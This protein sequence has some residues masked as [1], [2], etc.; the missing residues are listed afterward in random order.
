MTALWLLVALAQAPSMG[1]DGD[2]VYL[3]QDGDRWHV[4]RR[5]ADGGLTR[6]PAAAPVL[7]APG[8]IAA[9][10]GDLFL[11]YVA[12]PIGSWPEAVAIGD[13][14]SDGRGD[15][16]VATSSYFDPDNDNR[17]HVFLQDSGGALG[18]ASKYLVGGNPQTIA[19]GDVNGDGRD[20]VV[21]GNNSAIGLFLQNEAGTLDPMMS[22]PTDRSFKVA[23]G[24]LDGDWRADVVGIDWGTHGHDVDVFLQ[25]GS[26]GLAAP[27]TYTVAH[28]G[29]DDLTVG[30]VDGDG[31]KDVTVMS[32]Q[33][34]AY[35]NLGI[36][37]QDPGGGMNGP[38]YYD[39]GG[40]QLTGGVGVGDV[41]GD[42]LNDVVVSYGG[43]RPSSFIAV[44]PQTVGGTLGAPM[45]LP[46]YDIPEPVEVSDVDGDGRHDV[47]V[48]HGG[49]LRLGVYLQQADGTLNPTE[50]LYP[51]PYASHYNPHGLAVGDLNG[52]GAVDVAIADYNQGLIVLYGTAIIEGADFHTL[53]PCRVIDTRDAIAPLGGPA[54]TTGSD[55]VFR[56][57]GTCEIPL[58]AK[59]VSVNMTVT[60]SSAPGHLRL[61]PGE[62]SVPP[63]SSIN[64]SEGQTRA[65]NA[66]VRLNEMGELA[67]FVGG[68]PGT[69]HFILDVG[70]Y[71]E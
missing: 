67:A 16:V 35:D 29:Y 51:I 11:P 44:F 60:G 66:I 36:L 9:Q 2:A 6:E 68:A 26:G 50:D 15:A 52:D 63:A 23:V 21:V 62:T 57:A 3:K 7:S 61:H 24:D 38:F 43:N 14:N 22:V 5:D 45:S 30:D 54:L 13:L 65:N 47:L 34:Y 71:F 56:I 12:H 33:L 17:I 46:S 18:L 1:E 55:R 25:N 58:T 8:A 4:V 59:A 40:D 27:V 49:W 69:V 31:R 39:L 41:T 48:L 70:G 53:N 28:G 64:Y 19:V 10:V 20:D 37:L 42:R 32:G